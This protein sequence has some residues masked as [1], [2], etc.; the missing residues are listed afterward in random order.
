MRLI[1]QLLLVLGLSM[2]G[3]AASVCMGMAAGRR[4]GPIVGLIS[5]FHVAMLL[6]GYGLGA[7]LPAGFTALYPWCAAAL[8]TGMGIK[9][10]RQARRPEEDCAGTG[11]G[12]MAAMALAT[13]LDAMTVG[14]AFAIMEVPPVRA[15]AM[16]AAVMG[17]LSVAGAGLGGRVGRTR[18]RAAR[19]AGGAILCLLGA[20]LLLNALGVIDL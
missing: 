17:S 1:E 7:G 2:D 4:I 6:A 20:K 16:V 9:M 11:L 10:L 13:S 18:R 8:L 3:F 19:T 15:G 5:G 14:V 12:D